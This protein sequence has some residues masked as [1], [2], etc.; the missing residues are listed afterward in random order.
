M[1]GLT[2]NNKQSTAIPKDSR[3]A[4]A[5]G[6]IGPSIMVGAATTFLG[7]M[8]M[9]FASYF[10]FRVFF[11]LFIIIISFGVRRADIFRGLGGGLFFFFPPLRHFLRVALLS[12]PHVKP[13]PPNKTGE[14]CAMLQIKVHHTIGGA[15]VGENEV[16]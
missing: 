2:K 14:F 15:G 11:R 6:E 8:P 4:S 10:I 9:A 13:F 5:L 3:I 1:S 7:I 16:G 12:R